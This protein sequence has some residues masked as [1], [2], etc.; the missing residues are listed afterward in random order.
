MF[1]GRA[2]VKLLMDGAGKAVGGLAE[3]SSDER[4]TKNEGRKKKAK[5]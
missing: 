3:T 5:K 1:Y 4:G 2:A